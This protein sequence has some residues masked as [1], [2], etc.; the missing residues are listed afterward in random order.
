MVGWEWEWG[1][2]WWGLEEEEVGEEGKRVRSK[3][4]Q[5]HRMFTFVRRLFRLLLLFLLQLCRGK[6][7]KGG[8]RGGIV[9]SQRV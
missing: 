7:G 6:W 4:H 3:D 1:S 2:E 8:V 5:L 9:P